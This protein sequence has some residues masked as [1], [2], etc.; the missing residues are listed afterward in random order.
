ML[1][2]RSHAELREAVVARSITG[3]ASDLTPE[4]SGRMS[5]ES[6]GMVMPQ[7]GYTV[8][9]VANPDDPGG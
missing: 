6:P 8:E 5:R 4:S 7:R 9:P 1:A 3:G 2:R